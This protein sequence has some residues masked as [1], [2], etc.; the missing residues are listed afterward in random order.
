MPNSQNHM[1]LWQVDRVTHKIYLKYVV[2]SMEIHYMRDFCS[3]NY[4]QDI[5]TGDW[6]VAGI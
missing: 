2:T 4:S 5:N 3:R 1:I 6:M